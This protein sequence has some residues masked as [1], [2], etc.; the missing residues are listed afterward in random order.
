MLAPRSRLDPARHVAAVEALASR[1]ARVWG[2]YTHVSPE[3]LDAI[4]SALAVRYERVRGG[5]EGDARWDLWQRR[6]RSPR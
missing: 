3:E 6:D 2:V 5:E 1:Y 4:R